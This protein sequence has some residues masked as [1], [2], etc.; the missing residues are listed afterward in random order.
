MISE[1]EFILFCIEAYKI[2][3]NIKGTKVLAEFKRHNIFDFLNDFYD[4]L[5]TQSMKFIIDEID[6]FVKSKK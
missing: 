4:I 2:E 5:H 3:K 1:Q 6:E